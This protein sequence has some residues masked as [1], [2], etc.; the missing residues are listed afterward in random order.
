MITRFKR[1]NNDC[2][3]EFAD[4]ICIH[5]NDTHPA[6]C[7]PEMMRIFMDEE[8]LSWD[9]AWKITVN[10]LTFTNHTVLPE[11]LEKWPVD[12]MKFLLPRIYNYRR[13]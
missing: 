12:M 5:I 1:Y 2:L 10:S 7:G 4:K 13:N 8:G 11:A 3:D 9:D 6:L